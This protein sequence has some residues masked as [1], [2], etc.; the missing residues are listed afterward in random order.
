MFVSRGKHLLLISA[1]LIML[2]FYHLGLL[3][4]EV[5]GYRM[6][7]HGMCKSFDRDKTQPI[8][9]TSTFKTADEQA[10]MWFNLDIAPYDIILVLNAKWYRPDGLL[11]KSDEWDRKVRT[12]RCWFWTSLPI[13]GKE[14]SRYIGV[15]KV[16]VWEGITFLF[17]EEFTIGMYFIKV[18]VSGLPDDLSTDLLINGKDSGRVM[19]GTPLSLSVEFGRRYSMEV[20]QYVSGKQNVRYVCGNNILSFESD[21]ETKTYTFVYTTQYRLTVSS[22][23]GQPEGEGWYDAGRVA[24]FSVR[25]PVMV[26]LYMYVFERWSGD[27]SST[28]PS[29]T[30]VMDSPKTVIALW[31]TDYTAT[32]VIVVAVV[33][34]SIGAIALIARSRKKRIVAAAA[35]LGVTHPEAVQPEAQPP[36]APSKTVPEAPPVVKDV[37]AVKEIPKPKIIPIVEAPSTLDERLYNYIVEH[38]GEIALSQAAK[39]LGISLDEL[40]ASIDR[41]KEQGKLV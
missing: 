29:A 18:S 19:G 25:S 28:S 15:W 36:I 24:S 16:E 14:A 37:K 6:L 5:Q 13:S 34:A 20:K 4:V 2:A 39:D 17:R 9:P 22:T 35:P 7:E 32:Y 8:D 31:R 3:L 11:Q 38:G 1:V 23:Q 27:S 33:G 26:G 21:Q 41:L 12:G 40:K 10:T 30:V